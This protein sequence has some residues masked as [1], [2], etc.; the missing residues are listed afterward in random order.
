MP[1]LNLTVIDSNRRERTPLAGIPADV[2]DTLEEV[3][4]DAPGTRLQAGPFKL[5][6]GQPVVVADGEA[7]DK[8]AAETWLVHARSYAYHRPEDRGGKF[9]FAGNPT[10]AGYARFMA[11]PR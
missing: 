6:K 10:K 11:T 5:D 1:A 8:D 2:I 4:R 3:L 7:G 9:T